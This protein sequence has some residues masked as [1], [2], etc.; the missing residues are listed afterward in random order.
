[1]NQSRKPQIEMTK[2]QLI[3]FVKLRNQSEFA[4]NLAFGSDADACG[5]D[6]K[7]LG[8]PDRYLGDGW[9]WATPHGFLVEIGGKMVLYESLEEF[10]KSV[11]VDR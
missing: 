5:F 7:E 4:S 9:T 1:M 10:N 6:G 3:K 2:N 8:K 11:A